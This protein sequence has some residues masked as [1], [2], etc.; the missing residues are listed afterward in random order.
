MILSDNFMVE[1]DKKKDALLIRHKNTQTYPTPLVEIKRDTLSTMTLSQA[2]QFIGE[3]LI[4][5][6]PSLRDLFKDYLWSD[7]GDPP[8]K[9]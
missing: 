9:T 8:R 2:S 5:L 3:R 7:E 4:L 1:Y 6:I